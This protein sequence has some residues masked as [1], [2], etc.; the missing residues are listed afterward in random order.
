[1]NN[2]VNISKNKYKL[3]IIKS[4]NNDNYNKINLY[5]QK[6]N[7]SAPNIHL[8][9]IINLVDKFDKK[10]NS[11][12]PQIQLKSN[13]MIGGTIQDM[14]NKNKTKYN[15]NLNILGGSG[16]TLQDNTQ[17]VEQMK[18]FV[19]KILFKIYKDQTIVDTIMRSIGNST[20]VN[21]QEKETPVEFIKK[22]LKQIFKQ[23]TIVNTIISDSKVD[24]DLI[25]K[26]NSQSIPNQSNSN[27]N[28]FTQL[29]E[30][31]NLELIENNNIKKEKKI[32]SGAES[33]SI[34]SFPLMNS[35][36]TNSN[37]MYKPYDTKIINQNIKN[38]SLQTQLN[39]INLH[40]PT[41]N[42]LF[43]EI[44]NNNDKITNDKIS[45]NKLNFKLAD[46]NIDL[47]A[48]ELQNKI[49]LGNIVIE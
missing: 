33:G 11:S 3:K 44:I 42:T 21:P 20:I 4:I 38:N 26:I 43:V 9:K 29:K 24:N 45:N 37:Y 17:M 15:T 32:S 18:E 34:S 46:T 1:M 14:L 35:Q 48:N 23:D 28:Q 25:K 30:A 22:V 41:I 8:E 47:V 5:L 49:I 39:N 6:F 40:I 16:L 31:I 7:K 13:I 19:G 12:N 2:N 27:P 36:F 10:F